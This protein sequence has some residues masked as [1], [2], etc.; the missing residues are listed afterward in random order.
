[1]N[2]S[3]EEQET[4]ITYNNA[5]D[6]ANV[7]THHRRLISELDA[8]CAEDPRCSR[9]NSGESFGEYSLPKSWVHIKRPRKLSE[10]E[11]ERRANMLRTYAARRKQEETS[12]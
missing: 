5:S 11:R 12:N 8:I 10:S 6:T 7:Y 2:L 4:L 9:E 1:M 3:L